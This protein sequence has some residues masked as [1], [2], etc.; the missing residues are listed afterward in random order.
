M[1]LAKE[2]SVVELRKRCLLVDIPPQLLLLNLVY[3]TV[4]LF[5][6]MSCMP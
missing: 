4:M 5:I 6:I 1:V 2:E 3:T